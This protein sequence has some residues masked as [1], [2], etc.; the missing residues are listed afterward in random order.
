MT[1]SVIGL[2]PV[3]VVFVSLWCFQSISVT[4]THTDDVFAVTGGLTGGLTVMK[5]ECKPL[6]P[7]QVEHTVHGWTIG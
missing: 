3:F 2:L 6:N 4:C 5:V 1:P 7:L